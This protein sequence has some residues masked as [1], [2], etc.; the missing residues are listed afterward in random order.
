MWELYPNVGGFTFTLQNPVRFIDP[1]G[2]VVEDTDGN[3]VGSPFRTLEFRPGLDNSRVVRIGD[4]PRNSRIETL[5]GIIRPGEFRF[6]DYVRRLSS[7]V[8]AEESTG[9]D[10]VGDLETIERLN[11]LAKKIN[12]LVLPMRDL[13]LHNYNLKNVGLK[14]IVRIPGFVKWTSIGV[15]GGLTINAMATGLPWAGHAYNTLIGAVG[16]AGLPGMVAATAI[17]SYVSAGSFF[18]QMV[19]WIN[20]TGERLMLNSVIDWNRGF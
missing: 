11:K 9:T 16:A 14:R 17:D 8:N 5:P 12:S 10:R 6:E 18:I 3:W 1:T 20:T 7:G 15:D 19:N 2:M 4:L 13:I